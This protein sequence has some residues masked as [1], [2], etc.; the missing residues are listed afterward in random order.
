MLF[1]G[2]NL[3]DLLKRI[4]ELAKKSKLVGLSEEEKEEHHRLRQE[5]IQIFRG[6]F[7]ET[8]MN[9]KVV[10]EAGNDITPEKLLKE[11]NKNKNQ[12]KF[13]N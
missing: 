9:V 2:D 6:N 10:D 8:L 7:K 3:K 4:N 12:G 1:R 13:L 5:Y 11:Q